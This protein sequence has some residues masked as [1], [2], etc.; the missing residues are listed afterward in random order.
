MNQILK[1]AIP[2]IHSILTIHNMI[3][4]LSFIPS[5]IKTQENDWLALKKMFPGIENYSQNKSS[6]MSEFRNA[7][8][9]YISNYSA[10]LI[11]MSL[12]RGA[13]IYHL[14]SFLKPKSILDLGSGFSTF[15]FAKHA[16][17]NKLNN[18]TS[19]DDSQFWLEETKKFL[20]NHNLTPPK[21]V[22]WDQFQ[23]EPKTNIRIDFS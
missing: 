3:Y 8:E 19:V 23:V 17:V 11:S 2:T 16:E 14:C 15:I 13:F 5:H 20:L 18:I 6:I 22:T 21:L 1:K 10:E 4:E 7:F 12:N 9:D